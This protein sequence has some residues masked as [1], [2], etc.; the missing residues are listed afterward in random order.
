M[1]RLL[2]VGCGDVGMR[3]L[4]ALRGRYRLYAL[5]HSESR[6]DLLRAAGVVPVQGD[7]DD[8]DSLIRLA[9]IAQDVVHLAPPPNRGI[10][11]SRTA[12]LIRALGRRGSLPQRFVYI[13][14]SGVYGDCRGEWVSET[15][16]LCPTSERA[17]RRV[18]A[19]NQLREWGVA[20][21]IAV[22][23]LRVPGIYAANR[24]PLDRLAA[25]TPTLVREADSYTNHIHADDLA[26]AV[27]ASLL[28]GKPGRAY[29][30][31]DDSM[32]KMGDYFDLVAQRHGLP[33][34]PRI[35]WAEAQR[36][37]PETLLSFM[38]ESRRL[39]NRRL[40]QELRVRLR[41]PQVADALPSVVA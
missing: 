33:L 32:L 27:I 7:L 4:P 30:I 39:V 36:R 9:G 15:R 2:I 3:M 13:S 24:L 38:R 14:T 18:D 21:S 20:Q 5:T 35:E 22:V 10:A 16:R 34:P 1:R 12:N 31:N 23:I 37:I 26:R 25:G 29:N 6:H 17:Y 11:D 28:R 40:K 19:E 41:Y 8:A